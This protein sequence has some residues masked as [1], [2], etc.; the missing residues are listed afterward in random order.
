MRDAFRGFY[1]P[2]E[3]EFSALWTEGTVALDANALLNLYRYSPSTASQF[4]G[5]LDKLRSRLWLPYQAGL[6][7]QRNRVSVIAA[8]SAAHDRILSEVDRSAQLLEAELLKLKKHEALDIP[9]LIQEYKDQL[10]PFRTRIAD[11][12]EAHHAARPAGPF[13]DPTWHALTELFAGRVGVPFTGEELE[14]I[15]TEGALRY[16]QEVPPGYKDSAKGDPDQYGDLVIWKELIRHAAAQDRPLLFVTDDSK[17]DWWR[18]ESGKT[19]GPRVELV[20]EFWKACSQ[21]VYFY[22]PD[23]FLT[24]AKDR[25]NADVSEASIGE[26]RAVSEQTTD[27]RIRAQIEAREADLMSRRD[28]MRA[29][30]KRVEDG[31]RMAGDEASLNDERAAIQHELKSLKEDLSILRSYIAHEWD[32]E[33]GSP[34]AEEASR[35]LEAVKSQIATLE[36]RDEQLNRRLRSARL[37]SST[38][39]RRKVLSGRLASIE[40]E[41]S[42]VQEVLHELSADAGRPGVAGVD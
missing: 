41:L 10:Q 19:L 35:M 32:D 13:E 1:R 34:S 4:Y 42:E 40:R 28:D 18:V 30:L 27:R 8:Q 36:R 9:S 2:T 20:E 6:E 33:K 12:R 11:M 22:S 14:E 3:E 37:R 26:A 31:I 7:F 17:E 21:P 15:Y 39:E 23:Q 38:P 25:V 24:F 5:V 29:S 16:A